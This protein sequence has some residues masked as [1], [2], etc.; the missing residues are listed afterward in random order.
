MTSQISK[1]WNDYCSKIQDKGQTLYC[2]ISFLSAFSCVHKI[3][4]SYEHTLVH[5]F[6][7]IA[8]NIVH[9]FGIFLKGSCKSAEL[10]L[11]YSPRGVKR[12]QCPM[13]ER[14]NRKS[15]LNTNVIKVSPLP[16]PITLIRLYHRACELY[17]EI[18][19]DKF[20]HIFDLPIALNIAIL[21]ETVNRSFY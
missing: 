1:V 11:I 3:M 19:V 2:F 7:A 17:R 18:Y 13:V 6:S 15:K 4:A 10:D 20:S 14:N 12:V 9:F 16:V 5:L 21:A 8:I